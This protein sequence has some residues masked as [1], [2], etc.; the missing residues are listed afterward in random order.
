M[1][2][3]AGFDD[4]QAPALGGI[5]LA[6]L[7]EMPPL[8]PLVRIGDRVPGEGV[9]R[10]FSYLGEGGAFDGRYVGFWGAWGTETRTVRLYCPTEGNKDRI[11]YCNRNLVCEDTGETLADPASVCDAT[12]CYQDKQ[13][14]VH[15]GIFA[16]D[17]LGRGTRTV[18]K[19]GARF[20]E[21]LFWNYSGKTPCVGING[22][23]QEGAEDDGEAARWRS[24]AFVAISGLW[25][26]FKAV[27]GDLVGVYLNKQPGQDIFTVVDTRTPGQSVDPRAPAASKVTEVGLERDGLRG[28]WLT[29]SAKMAVEGGTEE[30]G[31]A[32]VY[33]TRLPR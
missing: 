22:H 7:A 3:F 10:T 28:S 14:P 30:D 27:T 6:P 18:A 13:V 21:F 20:D 11:D 26:A 17:T 4:E 15:Q 5:Y 24:S 1:V 12:G 8:T 23:G 32:G 25:T 9:D 33:I 2:V 19:S 16:H 29:I 31:M